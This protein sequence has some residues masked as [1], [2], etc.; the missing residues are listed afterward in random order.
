MLAS[1]NKN[2][3]LSGFFT[4]IAYVQVMNFIPVKVSTL[5]ILQA[6]TFLPSNYAQMNVILVHFVVLG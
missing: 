6:V 5:Y 4:K 2:R 3:P 1:K